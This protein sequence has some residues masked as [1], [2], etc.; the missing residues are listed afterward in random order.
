M[1]ITLEYDL[2]K[3]YLKK[4]KGKKKRKKNLVKEKIV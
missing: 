3:H 2:I 1:L 4:T